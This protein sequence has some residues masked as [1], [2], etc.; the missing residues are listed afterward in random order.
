M[1][2]AKYLLAALPLVGSAFGAPTA[3]K[4]D[5][6]VVEDRDI[7]ILNIVSNFKQEIDGPVTLI[8]QG[9]GS[10][11]LTQNNLQEYLT[12]I[13]NAIGSTTA[14]V[15]ALQKRDLSEMTPEMQKRQADLVNEV[16]QLLAGVIQ[17]VVE[18]LQVIGADLAGIPIIG[19]LIASIIPGLNTLLIGVDLV[20]AGVLLVVQ[21]LLGNVAGLLNGVLGGLGLGGLLGGLL[22]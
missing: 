8:K 5:L 22:G 2:F 10:T 15:Q 4:K 18:A 1:L 3:A 17:E 20:L 19:N 9:A 14:Q 12:T 21:S 11:A 7:N 6:A 16:G 13:S